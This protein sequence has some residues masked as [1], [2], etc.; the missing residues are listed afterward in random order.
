MGPLRLLILLALHCC[1][2]GEHRGSLLR[3]E[4]GIYF[5]PAGY[6]QVASDRF[7]IV[8]AVEIPKLEVNFDQPT[9]NCSLIPQTYPEA[10][11]ICKEYEQVNIQ[12]ENN[13]NDYRA[14]LADLQHQMSAI[15]DGP[16]I[17]RGKRALPLMVIGGLF[18][19]FA[20]AGNAYYT[21]KRISILQ[22]SAKHLA[23][24][25]YNLKHK[26][27][28]L[29]DQLATVTKIVSE[30][31]NDM[32]QKVKISDNNLK[33]ITGQFRDQI[34]KI[35]HSYTNTVR[36]L[37]GDI[38]LLAKLSARALMTIPTVQEGYSKL[39]RQTHR[40]ID[41]LN[42]LSSGRIPKQLVPPHK[43]KEMIEHSRAI[44]YRTF[45]H[46]EMTFTSTSHFYSSAD[47]LYTIQD[48]HIS[49]EVEVILRARNQNFLELF[50]VQ[51]T[52][53]PFDMRDKTSTP[54][55]H[56][57]IHVEN[58]YLA[59][60]D[61]NFVE[62]GLEQLQY[63]KKYG[64]LRV[65]DSKMLQISKSKLTCLTA[66][67]WDMGNTIIEQL[68]DFDYFP[69]IQPQPSLL[70]AGQ[71]LLISGFDS[72]WTLNCQSKSVPMRFQG[73]PYA[74]IK[75]T[76]LCG[77]SLASRQTYIS[78]H[79]EG[80][81]SALDDFRPKYV[82]NAAVAATFMDKGKFKDINTSQLLSEIPSLE[83]PL[84]NIREPDTSNVLVDNSEHSIAKLKRLKQLIDHGKQ[85]YL[86]QDAQ[87]QNALDVG[88]WFSNSKHV[89][90]AITFVLSL[91]GTV[92]LGLALFA[93]VRSFRLPFIA[94][95]L[96]TQHSPVAHAAPIIVSNAGELEIIQLVPALLVHITFS[97]TVFVLYKLAC[98]V[99]REYSTLKIILPTGNP[100]NDKRACDLY[101]EVNSGTYSC[102]LYLCTIRANAVDIHTTGR[103]C[104]EIISF[105]SG[106]CLRRVDLN[107]DATQFLLY[108]SKKNLP[109]PDRL[110]I[111]IW[112]SFKVKKIL[113]SQFIIRILAGQH[114]IFTELGRRSHNYVVKNRR[115]NA[116][117]V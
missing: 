21:H 47:T 14:E 42:S 112:K 83:L 74:I 99:Y 70:D 66:L 5:R 71:D 16:Q 57:K 17:N 48:N 3:P 8:I 77:C 11:N 49:I 92:A 56:T 96:L 102:L 100:N 89:G 72:D 73:H 35:A 10:G 85:L 109:L 91:I 108:V 6:L 54:K 46:L 116:F 62:I 13:I 67:F 44:L 30:E 1:C 12:L 98:Y 20:S 115:N 97:I 23:N 45:P 26:Y 9:I 55:A 32:K 7:Y 41:G 86:T 53:V 59:I 25:N 65:C 90:L 84:I 113:E 105:S 82:I 107:W 69:K 79:Y 50:H 31:I 117:H 101:V 19:A 88:N 104:P 37:F 87:D 114:G 43:L 68:C 80:C 64:V 81:A 22:E 110:Y 38:N 33:S 58:K 39:L 51:T 63:C 94:G 2:N 76:S 36:R 95:A 52:F 60:L 106:C 61:K 4:Y 111:P 24:Q 29:S 75:R 27:I 78:P 40:F 34:N 28:D 103:L 18:S 93:C 15:L